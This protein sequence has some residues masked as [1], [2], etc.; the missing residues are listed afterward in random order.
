MWLTAGFLP[1][2]IFVVVVIAPLTEE[3]VFRGFMYRGLADRWG[4]APAVLI[5]AGLWA[6]AHTQ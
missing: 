2:L 4:A 6:L 3:V 1:L 5:T